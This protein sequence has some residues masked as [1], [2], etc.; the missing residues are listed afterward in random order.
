MHPDQHPQYHQHWCPQH[1]Q[2]SQHPQYIVSILRVLSI[3]SVLHEDAGFYLE[4]KI[5]G[6]GGGGSFKYVWEGPTQSVKILQR[7][8]GEM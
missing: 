5:G 7:V 1:P 3:I 4:K 2:C 6:G 8:H